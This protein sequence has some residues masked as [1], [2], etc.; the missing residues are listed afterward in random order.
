MEGGTE[1]EESSSNCNIW[2]HMAGRAGRLRRG[3]GSELPLPSTRTLPDL[4][5]GNS[6]DSGQLPPSPYLAAA[7]AA[8]PS[9]PTSPVQSGPSPP[10]RPGSSGLGL[11]Q[12]IYLISFLLPHS[13]PD[14]IPP[15]LLPRPAPYS[16]PRLYTRPQR[17]HRT[18]DYR[19][20]RT[21]K[22]K[23]FCS[24]AQ[25]RYWSVGGAP[26]AL[27]PP[28]LSDHAPSAYLTPE[29]GPLLGSLTL[30]V[31]ATPLKPEPGIDFK[32][33]P[34]QSDRVPVG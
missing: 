18:Q 8:L 6:S 15:H 30:E 3:Q 20:P 21:V 4:W 32:F 12:R 11:T 1:A 2:C 19:R 27:D 7:A 33:T 25:V 13:Y 24:R 28:L 14:L 23:Q 10:P 17:G 16:G 22:S 26:R 34:P 31:G 5:S 9:T 29:A